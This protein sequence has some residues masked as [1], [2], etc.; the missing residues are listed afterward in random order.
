M[1]TLLAS[2]T[3]QTPQFYEVAF[4]ALTITSPTYSL[5]GSE[6]Y[7]R[8]VVCR[9]LSCYHT[10]PGDPIDTKYW[11]IVTQRLCASKK[12]LEIPQTYCIPCQLLQLDLYPLVLT[13]P[14]EVPSV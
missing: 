2:A 10:V 3:Q 7:D 1:T 8:H 11:L 5:P 13:G 4:S 9:D 12:R 14:L 6:P